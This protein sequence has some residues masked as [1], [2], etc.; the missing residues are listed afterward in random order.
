MRYTPGASKVTYY[1]KNPSVPGRGAVEY[2]PVA[3]LA[4]VLAHVPTCA[5]YYTSFDT[6]EP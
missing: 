2:D 5:A 4:L 3:F 6:L 1:G